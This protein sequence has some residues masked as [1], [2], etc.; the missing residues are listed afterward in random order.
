MHTHTHTRTHTH[1]HTAPVEGIQ[2]LSSLKS[3]VQARKDK[4]DQRQKLLSVLTALEVPVSDEPALLRGCG[5][6]RY[7]RALL[8]MLQA[9]VSPRLAQG[10]REAVMEVT[11]LA[12]KKTCVLV[13]HQ[14]YLINPY[15]RCLCA[16]LTFH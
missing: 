2:K 3:K 6:S 4:E 13:N 8:L 15:H 16:K 9:V 12:N 11:Q 14:T 10:Q 7:I 5:R 1:T